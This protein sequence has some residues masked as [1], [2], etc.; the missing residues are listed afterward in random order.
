MFE[1]IDVMRVKRFFL[2]KGGINALLSMQRVA[3][4]ANGA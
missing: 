4:T 2:F 1:S 3:M